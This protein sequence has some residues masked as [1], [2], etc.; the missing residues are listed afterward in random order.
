M[1]RCPRIA[2]GWRPPSRRLRQAGEDPVR[3][4]RTPRIA[5]VVGGLGTSA[6]NTGDALKRLPGPVTL[7]FMPYGSDI[8]QQ[9]TI[10]RGDRC[11]VKRDRDRSGARAARGD[12]ARALQ[13]GRLAGALPISMTALSAGQGCRK[14]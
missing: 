5:I 9:M 13:R 12:G 10:A 14:P 11:G 4:S 3:Q 7:A 8:E 1:A 6:T 2:P